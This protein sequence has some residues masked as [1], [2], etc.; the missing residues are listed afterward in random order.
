MRFEVEDTGIGIPHDALEV[1]FQPF[2]Q[3]DST[4]SRLRGGTGLGLAIS[5]RIVEAMG[6]R[7]E[8]AS[9]IGAGSMFSFTLTLPLAPDLPLPTQD[10]EFG[11]WTPARRHSAWCCWWRTTSSTA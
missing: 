5:Q 7:I 2:H 1:V 9:R 8:V 3:V 10:S 6:G 11:G 4:R